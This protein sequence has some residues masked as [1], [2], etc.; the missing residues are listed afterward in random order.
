MEDKKTRNEPS[1]GADNNSNEY[2]YSAEHEN[3]NKSST[4]V[5]TDDTRKRNEVLELDCK[6]YTQQEIAEKV[7]VS[8]PTVSR[9]LKEVHDSIV[10]S[11][12][13]NVRQ[14]YRDHHR[15]KLAPDRAMKGLWS[16][17]ED[18]NTPPALRLRAY[19]LI[20]QGNSRKSQATSITRTLSEWNEVEEVEKAN[21]AWNALSEDERLMR[22][23]KGESARTA[24][25]TLP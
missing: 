7:G 1:V 24:K 11:G 15:A 13:N 20:M 22:T 3:V 18:V 10:E 21:R 17:A 25:Y 5:N 19:S 6:G 2:A 14:A 4:A 12:L 9:Y 23:L 8:Q 16:I